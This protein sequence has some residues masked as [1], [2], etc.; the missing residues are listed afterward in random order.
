MLPRE[1][2]KELIQ[3]KKYDDIGL[4]HRLPVVHL[5]LYAYINFNITLNLC[6]VSTLHCGIKR[7]DLVQFLLPGQSQNK[8][9]GASRQISVF[10]PG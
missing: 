5:G 10:Q 8:S 7:L 9:A 6:E 1:F 3:G 2:I 4:L